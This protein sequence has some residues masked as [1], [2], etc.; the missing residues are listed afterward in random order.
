LSPGAPC[1]NETLNLPSA[2]C[3]TT[4]FP[5]PGIVTGS[6]AAAAAIYLTQ[7]RRYG[8]SSHGISQERVN[9]EIGAVPWTASAGIALGALRPVVVPMGWFL[10][11]MKGKLPG[12]EVPL[13]NSAKE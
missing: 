6:V 4:A 2:G 3:P 5:I 13:D 12:R 8:T 9:P 7:H 11:R 1:Q 10:S